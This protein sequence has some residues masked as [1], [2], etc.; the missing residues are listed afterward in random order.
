MNINNSHVDAVILSNIIDNLHP[1][2]AEILIYM[3]LTFL[4]YKKY[5]GLFCFRAIG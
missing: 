5:L 3:L 1:D 2:D 4:N